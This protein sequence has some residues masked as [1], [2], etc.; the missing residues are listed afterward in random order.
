MCK[1]TNVI[2]TNIKTALKI[3]F[4]YEYLIRLIL[5]YIVYT[6]NSNF[7]QLYLFTFMIAN[8]SI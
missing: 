2:I 7:I 3:I 5:N 4:L 8:G 1:F 6:E